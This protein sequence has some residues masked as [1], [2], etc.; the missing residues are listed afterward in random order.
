MVP[1][2]SLN[3]TVPVRGSDLADILSRAAFSLHSFI[4]LSQ[5]AA[6][7]YWYRC[8]WCRPSPWRNHRNSFKLLSPIGFPPHWYIHITGT[9]ILNYGYIY[10]SCYLNIIHPDPLHVYVCICS[11]VYMGIWCIRCIYPITVV[12][13]PMLSYELI[14]KPKTADT[15]NSWG[16]PTQVTFDC[17]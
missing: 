4:W 3:M 2:T 6:L 16:E 12:F 9:D 17:Y 1:L 11:E 7:C 14:C 10:S 15:I 8:N 13:P 5:S